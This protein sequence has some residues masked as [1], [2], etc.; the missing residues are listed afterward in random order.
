[1]T[2]AGRSCWSDTCA[3][4]NTTSVDGETCAQPPVI[5]PTVI[6][7]TAIKT[8]ATGELCI[9]SVIENQFN[10]GRATAAKGPWRKIR[11]GKRLPNVPYVVVWQHGD[12]AI[13]QHTLWPVGQG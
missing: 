13:W 7:L 1:M 4:A 3:P 12:V 5:R 8:E 10:N 11:V 6:R 9:R 2:A